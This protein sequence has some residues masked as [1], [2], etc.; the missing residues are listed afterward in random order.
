MPKFNVQN[1]FFS[2]LANGWQVSN[3]ISLQSG[4]P[5]TPV[6]TTQRSRSGVNVG[7]GTQ[8]DRVMV[9]TTANIASFSMCTSLPGQAPVGSNPCLYTPVPYDKSKVRTGNYHQWFNPA[10]FSLAPAGYLGTAG[11]NMLRGP[12]YASWDFSLVKNTAMN[13]IKH[14]ANLEFRAEFF[15]FLNHTNFGMPV[16]SVFAGTISDAGQFSELPLST[17][18]SITST[19]GTSRQIQLALKLSF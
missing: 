15:N 10:M 19:S 16:G 14:E 5:F 9:N 4:Y 12:R 13:F 6:L 3:I 7:G 11:R 1:Q 18:G 17:A 2:G 8:P